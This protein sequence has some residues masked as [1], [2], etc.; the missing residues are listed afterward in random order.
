MEQSQLQE[1]IRIRKAS[2][3]HRSRDY[4]SVILFRLSSMFLC[5]VSIWCSHLCTK[6]QQLTS[7][8]TVIRDMETAVE[9]F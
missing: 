7:L 4:P 9:I 2:E 5:P 8:A 6:H 3:M 1:Q